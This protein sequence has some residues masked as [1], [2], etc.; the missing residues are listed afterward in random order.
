MK[1][2]MAS[3]RILPEN[4]VYGI[5]IAFCFWIAVFMRLY[6]IETVPY[7]VHIDEAGMGYD[8][9][10]MANYGVDRFQMSYPVYLTNFGGGQSSLYA[11]LCMLLIKIF[12]NGHVNLLLMRLP[13]IIISLLAYWAGVYAIR[14]AYGKKMGS[15][16]C[17]FTCC[18]ALFHY[19]VQIW[20]GL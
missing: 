13:G 20:F 3:R 5:M 15:C 11:F 1:I 8:A 2:Q 4:V 18:I 19:A 16:G 9:W 14:E 6:H 17:L 12:G 10:C 7:G